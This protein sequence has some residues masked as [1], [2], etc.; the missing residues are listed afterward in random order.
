MVLAAA[1]TQRLLVSALRALTAHQASAKQQHSA[2]AR[3]MVP[4]LAVLTAHSSEP[5]N[6]ERKAM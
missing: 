4:L 2:Q 3:L 5:D 1:I 6:L